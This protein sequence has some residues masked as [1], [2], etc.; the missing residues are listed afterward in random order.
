MKVLIVGLGSIAKKHIEAL[1]GLNVELEIVA[2]R[3]SKNALSTIDIQN[4]YSWDEVPLDI[5]FVLISNPTFEHKETI[6]KALKF[7]VPIFLEKPPLMSL[8]G[9]EV[10]VEQIKKQNS[11]IYTAFN[12]RFHPV[13]DWLKHN[14]VLK[15]VL[16]VQVY[17]GSYLPD[18]RKDQDYRKNY[19][20]IAAQGG[21]V[22]LDLIHE[23]DYVR[24]IF[25]L[26]EKTNTF[27]RKVSDL[28]MDSIDSAHYWLMYSR[29]NVSILLNYYRRD[30]KRYIEIVTKEDTIY[31]DLLNGRIT[32][33]KGKLLF[34]TK[35]LS[36]IHTYSEQMKYFIANMNTNEKFMNDFN[37]SIET[38]KIGLSDIK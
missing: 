15:N 4:V 31:A 16:E 25:G 17:C 13:V 37:E 12:L 30:P 27:Q 38:L 24:W 26:P 11:R 33:S 23:L 8:Q 29:F 21:G 32:N 10:L 3:S 18:W 1:K 19:S 2:L 7:Q 20:A 28:E 14:L 9:A 22:H 36:I 6:Q 34:E 35:N 5:S